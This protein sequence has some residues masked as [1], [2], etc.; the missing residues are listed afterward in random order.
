MNAAPRCPFCDDADPE[1]VGRWGGQM[2][3]AQWR[4][5]ACGSY[6]EA[7]RDSFDERAEDKPAQP[8][9]TEAGPAQAGPAAASIPEK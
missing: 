6:F 5:G 2:I 1:L 4:C 7:I 9:P 8:G 3:T